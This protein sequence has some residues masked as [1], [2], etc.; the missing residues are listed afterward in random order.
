MQLRLYL[1]QSVRSAIKF[2]IWTSFNYYLKAINDKIKEHY[3]L[4]FSEDFFIYISSD[5][6]QKRRILSRYLLSRKK[7]IS[8]LHEFQLTP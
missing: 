5:T 6:F 3:N 2:T 4:L 1:F 7:T 8:S